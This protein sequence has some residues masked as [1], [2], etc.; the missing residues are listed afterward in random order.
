MSLG[1]G[2]MLGMLGGNAE[3]V[4]VFKNS[5]GKKISSV[6]LTDDALKFLFEDNTTLK[7]SDEGQS[8]CETRYMTSDDELSYYSG[9][10]FLGAE[11]S[12]VDNKESD[13]EWGGAHEVAFL[14][15]QTSKGVIVAETHNE[16]NGY[17]GGF[18]IVASA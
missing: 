13:D 4:E 15:V 1:M 11:V 3:S 12:E 8:C 14:R 17:Y 5:I 6:E 16:H 9:A 10:E 2:V 18:W 7:L